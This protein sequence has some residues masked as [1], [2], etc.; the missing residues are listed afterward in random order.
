MSEAPGP[1]PERPEIHQTVTAENGFA[2][3]VIGADIHVLGGSVPVY[4]LRN[5][6]AHG[7]R[8][9]TWL[10]RLPSRMLN[11][12]FAVVPFTGREAEL[13]DLRAW[14]DGDDHR[15]VRWLHGP[16][17]AGK[18]RLAAEFAARSLAAGWKV[19]D[20]VHGPGAVLPPPGSQDL[21]IDGSAGVLLIVD[22]ADRWPL[23]HLGWLLSNSLVH[24]RKRPVRVLL[25]ART[26]DGMPSVRATLANE[27]T[28][29]SVRLLRPLP[30]D[31]EQRLQMLRAA[32]HGF[33]AQYEVDPP[34]PDDPP[35][36]LDTPPMGST[37]SLHMNAL[38]TVDAFVNGRTPPSGP[39][40]TTIYLLDREHA[41]WRYL[42]EQP[43][44]LRT[45]P[46][47][48]NRA[49]FAAVLSGAM[50]PAA[51]LQTLERVLPSVT[52]P[53]GV[54]SDHAYC[55]P[56][57]DDADTV[58]EPLY[59]DRLAEDF[60]ALSFPGH[61]EEYP[62][63]S[64][65]NSLCDSALAP[66]EHGDSVVSAEARRRA[67]T[68]LAAAAGRW[69]HLATEF[70]FPALR[71][72]PHLAVEAGSAALTALS[73]VADPDIELFERILGLVPDTSQ[74]DLDNGG[75]ALSTAIARHRLPRTTRPRERAGLL[76]SHGNRLQLARRYDEAID[77]LTESADLYLELAS[78]EI[79][80]TVFATHVTLNL[81]RVLTDAGR[82][83]DAVGACQRACDLARNLV[84]THPALF[85]QD[86]A[87]ALSNLGRNL[88]AMGR[89]AE[90]LPV[91]LESVEINR[92]MAELFLGEPTDD[93]PD[94]GLR[95]VRRPEDYR[96]ALA[97][98]L[99]N[100][101]YCQERMGLIDEPIESTTEA[102]AL[103][104]PLVAQRPQEYLPPYAKS[105]SNLTAALHR[106]GRRAE[107]SAAGEEAAGSWRRL[108]RISFPA[109]ALD[110]AETLNNHGSVLDAS[111]QAHRALPIFEEAVDVCHRMV[112]SKPSL[113]LPA[114]A[115]S[116]SNVAACLSL[117]GRHADA[118]RSNREA[119]ATWRE[120]TADGL[121][122]HGPRMVLALN[123]L[124]AMLWE[125]GQRAEALDA[126]QEAAEV[127]KKLADDQPGA[128]LI[129]QRTIFG[130]LSERLLA[131]GRLPE[132]LR[133]AQA[134]LAAARNL[135]EH[136]TSS[137]PQVARQ[138]R[139]LAVVLARLGRSGDAMMSL[140]AA[141]KILR[142]QV[143]L[144]AAELA[145]VLEMIGQVFEWVLMPELAA[146]AFQ[147]AARLRR[148]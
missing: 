4:V 42:H 66:P 62:A 32:L 57:A 8:S 143:P 125:L 40:G 48:M 129:E 49:V 16:G 28:D 100:L 69:P 35:A 41:H 140:K 17:G 55:Y 93:V 63:Q 116:Q 53:A 132:S 107:A 148:A 82:L 54:L 3:G 43:D 122:P 76:M 23:S 99:L 84:A 2:Y 142:D 71:R 46:A 56:A 75:A 104:R 124:A 133:W 111:G 30:P 103:L 94:E 139:S 59:P 7:G 27:E 77:Y 86:L 31:G 144:P 1:R 90:A 14:R 109:Y 95:K 135:A 147:E 21:R 58:L 36:L 45:P 108:T 91:L 65:A 96:A 83:E 6:R 131:I 87:M 39:A 13:Q 51:G 114:L 37:L 81:G 79:S 106:V 126:L 115:Q 20:V 19:V 113:A 141:E 60:L 123:N 18:T 92:R 67:V 88:S 72:R 120:I 50:D 24:Q 44:P 101:G 85:S 34:T 145:G 74:V 117:Q 33:A 9:R 102:V 10:R 89:R 130:H 121:E 127:V 128:Y 25:V 29:F 138:E 12:R 78:T 15:A 97:I 98:S 110:L 22:Y 52:D 80:A 47:I 61:E 118:V 105:L 112:R 11:A 26:A 38:V 146:P 64:W 134:A 137:L 5:W 73:E 136:H 119:I 70:V 68:F